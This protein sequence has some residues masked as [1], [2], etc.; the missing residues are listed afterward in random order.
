[1]AGDSLMVEP[2]R[3]DHDYDSNVINC[4]EH[5]LGDCPYHVDE[6]CQ[7]RY[8]ADSDER[9]GMNRYHVVHGDPEQGIR[10]AW[11]NDDWANLYA[12]GRHVLGIN[13]DDHGG[14]GMVSMIEMA[15]QLAE[16]Y[17][18]PFEVEGSVGRS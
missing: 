14:S 2:S 12:G 9:C 6:P 10:V 8:D 11:V 3:V 4:S 17:R 13:Y 18:I 5:D 1:M 15:R 16:I 7:F